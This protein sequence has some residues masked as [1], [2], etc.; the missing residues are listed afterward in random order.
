M[1]PSG[2]EQTR[3]PIS[4][5]CDSAAGCEAILQSAL[6][7]NRISS[8]DALALAVHA[9]AESLFS[10]ADQIRK[11]FHPDSIVS[12]V[13]DRNINYS[14]IC[15]SVCSFCA[16][17]R[18]PGDPEGYLLS[19]EEIHTKVEETIAL[20]GSGTLMQGG[21]HP[22]L[23]LSWYTDM[24]RSIKDRH[25]DFYLHCFSPTEI[26]AL[27]T[28]TSL[29]A[30]QILM[31]LK[32]AG[33]DSI[34]GGGGEILVDA[35]RKRRRSSCSTDQWLEVSATAHRLGLPTTAT[36]MIG[37]G[38]ETWMRA[39]HLER[40]REVQDQTGGFISFI[41][42]T[43]QPDNTPLGKKISERVS[44]PEY[45]RWLAVSRIFLDNIENLQVSWLTVGLEEGRLGLHRGANDFGSVMIEENVISVAGANHKA[46]EELLRENIEKAGFTPGLRNAGYKRL[47]ERPVPV[48]IREDIA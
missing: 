10:A 40:V 24:L 27:T 30:E 4:P 33:L 42:W 37:L 48:P 22:D 46:T 11:K 43:F 12:Y 41:P 32:E 25:P 17:Y 15:T 36:M 6:A 38:E 13:V 47:P 18:K 1:N 23:P 34:P 16:F 19:L 35:I 20:G 3:G 7:G 2:H 31:A 5:S 44:G 29:D 26:H 21:L 14:N 9:D 45:S 39:E 28:V 8:A